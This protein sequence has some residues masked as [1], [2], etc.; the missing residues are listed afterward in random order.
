M[1]S[2]RDQLRSADSTR[3]VRRPA[4]A[5]LKATFRALLPISSRCSF[6]TQQRHPRIGEL[7]GVAHDRGRSRLEELF[8]QGGEVLHVRAEQHRLT[9]NRRLEEIVAAGR[10]HAAADEAGYPNP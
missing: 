10:D 8:S 6:V 1:P 3:A 4:L 7:V 2:L 9:V 5:S